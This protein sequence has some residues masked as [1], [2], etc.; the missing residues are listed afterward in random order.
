MTSLE[1]TADGRVRIDSTSPDGEAARSSYDAVAV[2][3]GP[4][5]AGLLPEL[6]RVLR[7]VSTPVTYWR[8]PTGEHAAA[9]GFPILFNAR[10][11]D[12]YVLPS[13]EYPG[14]VKVLFHGG[15][16][17]D[18]ESSDPA[19]S[20]PYVR[21]VADYVRRHLPLLDASGPAILETCFYTMTS[22]GR[23][24][25]D[26]LHDGVT[27]GAGFSGSGFKH[28]PATGRMLAALA[29]GRAAGSGW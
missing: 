7:I 20:D 1:P 8:D 22:D 23:P 17:S 9:R 10:L 21:R 18:P 27:V 4:W 14:R 19:A 11:T 16:A 3:T 25:I 2:C 29:M 24:I 15:P 28:A 13:Y 6:D 26:R 12:V 5:A